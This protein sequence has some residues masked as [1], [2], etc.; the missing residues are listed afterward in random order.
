LMDYPNKTFNVITTY[1]NYEVYE[2]RVVTEGL[3]TGLLQV[4]VEVCGDETI[5]F[6]PY[7]GTAVVVEYL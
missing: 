4:E 2:L 5:V 6:V 3:I 1:S 7:K